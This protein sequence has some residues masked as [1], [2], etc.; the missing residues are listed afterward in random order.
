MPAKKKS[1]AL[2][3]RSLSD[4][5]AIAEAPNQQELANRARAERHAARDAAK[6][7]TEN[8]NSDIEGFAADAETEKQRWPTPGEQA[9][10]DARPRRCRLQLPKERHITEPDD[11]VDG[12]GRVNAH[13]FYTRLRSPNISI[14]M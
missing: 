9:A 14:Y 11:R 2:G 4:E 5:S 6:S 8:A 3:K 13:P 1:H 7:P 12:V 10:R